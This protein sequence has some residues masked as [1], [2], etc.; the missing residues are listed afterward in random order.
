M[1]AH[2][3]LQVFLYVLIRHAGL[4]D[5]LMSGS[6]CSAV[7]EMVVDHHRIAISVDDL[8]VP[9]PLLELRAVGLVVGTGKARGFIPL[10]LFL[11]D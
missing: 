6:R 8:A 5:A 2:A 4:V 9:E 3:G 1:I 10:I 7:G 11:L